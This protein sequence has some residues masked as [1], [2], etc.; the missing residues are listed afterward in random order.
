MNPKERVG[1]LWTD[2]IGIPKPA[3]AKDPSIPAIQRVCCRALSKS[4][5]T[6]SFHAAGAYNRSI[7][8]AQFALSNS[9]SHG[10]P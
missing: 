4:C 7:S 5:C 1:L 8:N 10:W 2:S 9:L 6:V 3:W